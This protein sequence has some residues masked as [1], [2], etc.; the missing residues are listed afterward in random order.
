ME[1]RLIIA[2]ALLMAGAAAAGSL[3]KAAIQGVIRQHRDQIR[4]CYEDQLKKHPKLEGKVVVRFSISPSGAV[5]SAKVV[6]S[7]ASN[8]ALETCIAKRVATW[9]FPKPGGEGPVVVTYPFTFQRSSS[10]DAGSITPRSRRALP[11]PSVACP[12]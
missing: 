5:S 2:C 12:G 4:A 1:R 6:E 11:L 10:P 7:T 9:V 3:D 8:A